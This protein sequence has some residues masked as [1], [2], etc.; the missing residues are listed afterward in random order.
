MCN[1]IKEAEE[2]L[3]ENCKKETYRKPFENVRLQKHSVIATGTFKT[4]TYSTALIKL[5][6]QKKLV[7][8]SVMHSFCPF[9]GEKIQYRL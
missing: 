6:G 7:E 9:C 3:T 1:C 4:A 2:K 8:M 5:T